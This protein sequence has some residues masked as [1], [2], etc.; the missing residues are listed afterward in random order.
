MNEHNLKDVWKF[1]NHATK[2]YTWHLN[3]KPTIFCRLDY[4]LTSEF[5]DN[6]IT[7]CKI[8]SGYKSDD[9]IVMLNINCNPSKRGPGYF[10]F[11]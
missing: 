7:D 9:S 5:I 6:V 1:L 2:Q 4:F 8:K 3:S 10:K 11:K